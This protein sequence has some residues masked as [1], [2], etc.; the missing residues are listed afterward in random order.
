[1]PMQMV[2]EVRKRLE[3]ARAKVAERTG[4]VLGG[5][6]FLRGQQA[7]MVGGGKVVQNVRQRVD[8]ALERLRARKP[9]M[10][11]TFGKN[12]QQWKLGERVKMLV[13]PKAG[14][15]PTG[16]ATTKIPEKPTERYKLRK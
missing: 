2:E 6:A 8:Q 15:P 10:I 7:P 12:I 9:N 16:K 1:M 14:T 13:E 4:G 3:G 5:T 11:P